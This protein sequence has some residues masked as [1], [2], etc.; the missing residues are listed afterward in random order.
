[1]EADLAASFPHLSIAGAMAFICSNKI[2]EGHIA[3]LDYG[4]ITTSVME[5]YAPSMKLD[6]DFKRPLEIGAIYSAPLA[7]ARNKGFDMPKVKMSEQQ[8]QFIQD[9]YPAQVF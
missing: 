9:N 3:H 6:F 7:E 1:M 2:G 5:P 4:K 8:L